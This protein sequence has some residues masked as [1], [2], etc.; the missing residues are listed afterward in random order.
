MGDDTMTDFE[1]R[2]YHMAK[3]YYQKARPD[4]EVTYDETYKTIVVKKWGPNGSIWYINVRENSRTIYTQFFDGKK[5]S[6]VEINKKIN[7]I[8]EMVRLE[9]EDVYFTYG[10]KGVVAASSLIDPYIQLLKKYQITLSCDMVHGN[11]LC[12][13]DARQLL[14][15]CTDGL[16]YFKDDQIV[17]ERWHYENQM[18]T[19]EPFVCRYLSPNEFEKV[20][21]KEVRLQS[22]KKALLYQLKKYMKQ[23]GLE[24]Y[25]REENGS[26]CLVNGDKDVSV[27]IDRNGDLDSYSFVLTYRDSGLETLR[28]HAFVFDE[29]EPFHTCMKELKMVL[30]EPCKKIRF[31]N[32]LF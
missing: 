13:S 7:E 27:Y 22:R 1:K 8:K 11:F 20:L 16:I 3:N 26:C 5:E 12:L 17:L 14:S 21:M 24:L 2:M 19:Y 29:H 31:R 30:K 23:V 28:N 4:V 25:L 10:S 9:A 32:R 6:S 15:D 18:E